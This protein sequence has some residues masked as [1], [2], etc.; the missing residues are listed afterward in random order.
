MA[1]THRRNASLLVY[2][3]IVFATAVTAAGQSDP[4]PSW[5]EGW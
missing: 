5:N 1:A 4:L 2:L 3:L